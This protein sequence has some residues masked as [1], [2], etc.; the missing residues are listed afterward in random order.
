MHPRATPSRCTA[1][2]PWEESEEPRRG[3][4]SAV[5]APG[6]ATRAR[7]PRSWV[8]VSLKAAAPVP[9]EQGTL[10]R[11]ISIARFCFFWAETKAA[12][13]QRF[14]LPLVTNHRTRVPSNNTDLLSSRREA[15]SPPVAILAG[16]SSAWRA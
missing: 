16:L 13:K 2:R 11:A 14:P 6:S 3:A 8:P 4:E 9:R 5:K 10:T 12:Q 7:S 15:R 1:S